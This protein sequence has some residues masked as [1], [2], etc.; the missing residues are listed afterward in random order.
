MHASLY[1]K[2]MGQDLCILAWFLLSFKI[3]IFKPIYLTLSKYHLS[4]TP[5]QADHYLLAK[6][7]R[8]K[9]MITEVCISHI[10][11]SVTA[12]VLYL[13]RN[14]YFY[15]ISVVSKG[16]TYYFFSRTSLSHN[17]LVII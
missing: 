8:L 10:P 16:N 7:I 11:V 14:V 6:F 5:S 12:K 9:L 1:L 2:E 4:F 17:D 15:H 3:Q 13:I